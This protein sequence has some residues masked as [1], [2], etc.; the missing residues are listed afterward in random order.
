MVEVSLDGV[1][2]GEA[3][4]K[5]PFASFT[6]E[7]LF[8]MAPRV[9]RFSEGGCSSSGIGFLL[10]DLLIPF[11]VNDEGP[12]AT[13]FFHGGDSGFI[14]GVVDGAGPSTFCLLFG[15]SPFVS[16]SVPFCI[17]SS[18]GEDSIELPKSVVC[19]VRD[20]RGAS[21]YL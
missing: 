6:F 8:C 14:L 20:P 12:S 1:D 7:W 13:T 16:A 4:L 17:S 18:F 19:I 2:S 11:S 3:L 21:S 15:R 5:L 9:V 10:P